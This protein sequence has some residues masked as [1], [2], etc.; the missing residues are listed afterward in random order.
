MPAESGNFVE[1]K[2]DYEPSG[3]PVVVGRLSTPRVAASS[4]VFYTLLAGLLQAASVRF[5]VSSRSD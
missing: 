2:V 4:Q 5:A 1:L 3:G